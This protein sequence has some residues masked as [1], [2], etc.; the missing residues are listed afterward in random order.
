MNLY[1]YI[2]DKVMQDLRNSG[3]IPEH[4]AADIH[5]QP[6]IDPIRSLVRTEDIPTILPLADSKQ[7]KHVQALALSLL[8]GFEKDSRVRQ[9]FSSLWQT[10]L[11][12]AARQSLMW[13]ILDDPDL[14][15]GFHEEIYDFVKSNWNSWL[16]N[17]VRWHGGPENVL[18]SVQ[19][20]ISDPKT[21]RTKD[22]AYLCVS[23]G[24]TNKENV[25]ALLN[26]YVESKVSIVGPVAQDLLERL[27][28]EKQTASA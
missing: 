17:Q 13:R 25:R 27:D 1:S 4:L 8:K 22:W 11:D 19:Q 10:E 3:S 26:C 23:L 2:A 20:R 14:D 5:R 9:F 12:F 21:T 24:A 16:D 15:T 18:E 28:T 7:P 6:Y